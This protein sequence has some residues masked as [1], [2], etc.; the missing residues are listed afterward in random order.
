MLSPI[1]S[2]VVCYEPQGLGLDFRRDNWI[3]L[4][5]NTH[6]PLQQP[7]SHVLFVTACFGYLEPSS[8]EPNA[9]H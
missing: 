9:T 3:F 7:L 5:L 4:K 8:G 6:V 2:E 1:D